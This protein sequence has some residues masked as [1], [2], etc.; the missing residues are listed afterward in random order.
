PSPRS[1]LIPYPTLFRSRDGLSPHGPFGFDREGQEPV[2]ELDARRLDHPVELFSLLEASLRPGESAAAQPLE[3]PFRGRGFRPRH[4][5][6]RK[7][8]RLN[9]S[10]VK[11]T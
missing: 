1:T 3:K 9:S 6:D 5:P 10:H 8:T 2:R 11:N 7:S 4:R